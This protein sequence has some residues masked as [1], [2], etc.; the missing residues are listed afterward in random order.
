MLASTLALPM[1]ANSETRSSDFLGPGG[2]G[3]RGRPQ[4]LICVT[5]S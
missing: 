3:D 2:R 1:D 4:A 5:V